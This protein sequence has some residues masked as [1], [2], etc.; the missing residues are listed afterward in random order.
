ME[1]RKAACVVAMVALVIGASGCKTVSKSDYFVVSLK[2]INDPSQRCGVFPEKLYARD[3]VKWIVVANYIQAEVGDLSKNSVKVE[4]S[5]ALATGSD[6]EI[7][8][9]LRP[10]EIMTFKLKK[11]LI[12]KKEFRFKVT[13]P[14]GGCLDKLPNPRIVIP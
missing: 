4:V 5:N 6:P 10:G 9:T 8:K 2:D 7:V 11:G 13:T 1:I 12:S 3:G 14:A